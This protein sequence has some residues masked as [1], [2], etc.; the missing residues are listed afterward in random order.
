MRC[1]L[2]VK[3]PTGKSILN[4]GQRGQAAAVVVAAV[5]PNPKQKLSVKIREGA[6]AEEEEEA[7]AG[8]ANKVSI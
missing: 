5:R 2:F 4:I 3:L 8:F 7:A 1:K 6:E